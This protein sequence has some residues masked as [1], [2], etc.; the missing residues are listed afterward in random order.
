MNRRK[1]TKCLA[2]MVAV[3]FA[4]PETLEQ[5]LRKALDPSTFNP[6]CLPESGLIY[7]SHRPDPSDWECQAQ[8]MVQNNE[9]RIPPGFYIVPDGKPA[10]ECYSDGTIVFN[11]IKQG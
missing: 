5:K 1:F 9:M 7:M 4:A 2:A 11:G 6:P 10:I 8:I 3:P